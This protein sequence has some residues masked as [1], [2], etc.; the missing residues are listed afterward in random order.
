[1]RWGFLAA[2]IYFWGGLFLWPTPCATAAPLYAPQGEVSLAVNRDLQTLL[3]YLER[4]RGEIIAMQ[5]ELVSR[6][7]VNPEH[8][9]KGEEDKLRWVEAKLEEYGIT[10]IERLDYMDARVSGKV[11]GNLI[12]RL[13]GEQAGAAPRRTLWLPMH[14]DVASPGPAGN[15]ISDPFA[16]RVEGDLM[17]GRGTEDNNQA[18]VSSLLL[19]E[20]LNAR[21][22]V[23]PMDIG[24]IFSSGALAN[25][26][27][28]IKHILKMRPDIFAP[29]DLILLLDYGSESGDFIEVAEKSNAW[30]KFT[31]TGK[32]G[33]ASA[34]QDGVNAFEAG[35]ELVHSLRALSKI[36]SEEDPLFVPPHSTFSATLTENY[37]S[38]IN[39]IPEQFVFYLDA[40]ILPAYTFEEVG[41][42][43]RELADDTERRE[44]VDIRFEMVEQTPPASVTPPD[45][46]VVSAL[47]GAIE[48]QLG[49]KPRLGGIGGVTMASSI[50][51]AGFYVAAWGML[52]NWRNKANEHASIKNHIIQA[53]VLARLLYSYEPGNAD[54]GQSG[55]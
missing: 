19:L 46:P 42:A 30:Y 24:L 48:E 1:M 2:W 17:Y 50:R 28:G 51:A 21:K 41:S 18:I 16:L 29:D 38:A 52:K 23:P 9:G 45:A 53:K 43:L 3:A 49:V 12:A 32:E 31:I 14:L 39:H 8:G 13:P 10:D 5:R 47:A 36:F 44:R 27:I 26:D 54:S 6:S 7:A 40:R 35:A 4:Q 34:P 15:W 37:S 20:A 22:I 11:R 25:Y 55:Q 33:H